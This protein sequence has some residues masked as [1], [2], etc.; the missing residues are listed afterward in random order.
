MPYVET[1]G[2]KGI[3]RQLEQWKLF[4]TDPRMDG[5]TGYGCKQKL[6]EVQEAVNKAL[7]N[8]PTYVGEEDAN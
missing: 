7:E 8:A 3:I 6:M 2:V 1:V 5:F 4:M